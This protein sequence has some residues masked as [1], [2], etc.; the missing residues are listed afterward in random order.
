MKPMKIS[1]KFE[2]ILSK[3][4]S[5]FG[6][7]VLY[8]RFYYGSGRLS[9]DDRKE[10]KSKL[11]RRLSVAMGNRA[12]LRKDYPLCADSV[13]GIR[14]DY[15]GRPTL[16]IKSSGD[17]SISFAYGFNDVWGAICSGNLSCGIDVAFPEEF[18]TPYPYQR[19]F[20]GRELDLL[21]ARHD[22]TL[23][24]AACLA[25]SGKESLLKSLG[26]GFNICE[27]LD[28]FVVDSQRYGEDLQIKFAF[29]PRLRFRFG[30]EESLQCKTI[31]E[32]QGDGFLSLSVSSRSESVAWY[33]TPI[34]VYHRIPKRS[35]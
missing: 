25:W 13:V 3:K 26:I 22:I 28:L 10:I 23:S 34:L 30:V 1:E 14:S 19:A 20:K 31:T 27:P 15:W 21:M 29:S 24:Q 17:F 2:K 4:F 18:S 16:E 35:Q 12:D 7:Q 8:T 6:S 11:A 5:R 33:Q 32:R 9:T